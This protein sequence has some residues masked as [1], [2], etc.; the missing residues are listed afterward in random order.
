MSKTIFKS[1]M[2]NQFRTIGQLGG[3][4]NSFFSEY[5]CKLNTFPKH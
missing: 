2:V 3:N 1:G 5:N 4:V